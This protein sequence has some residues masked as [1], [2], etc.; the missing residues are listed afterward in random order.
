MESPLFS[1][2][3]FR[4][5]Q[6][7][8]VRSLWWCPSSVRVLSSSSIPSILSHPHF[9][10]TILSS[11]PLLN[12][13][14]LLHYSLCILLHSHRTPSIRV[15]TY[16]H[17]GTRTAPPPTPALFVSVVSDANEARPTSVAR[18]N[19]RLDQQDIY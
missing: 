16:A 6:K 11:S 15:H 12:L 17:R 4:Q 9:Q 13:L 7:C 8:P 10:S 3:Q 18:V 14:H 5:Q 2:H 19:F 1:F